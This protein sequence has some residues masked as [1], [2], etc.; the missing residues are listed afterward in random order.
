[1]LLPALPTALAAAAIG[2]LAPRRPHIPA[3]SWLNFLHTPL[4]ATAMAAAGM[5]LIHYGRHAT[6]PTTK[7][8]AIPALYLGAAILG[9]GTALTLP[10]ATGYQ[11]IAAP[12]LALA[13]AI[14]ATGNATGT[15]GTLYAL[16][17][18][19]RWSTRLAQMARPQQR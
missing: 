2:L 13:A 7:D 4:I 5:F 8:L 16:A 18:A 10:L 9:I 12:P 6:S 1:M 19:T 11:I 17:A 3:P 15:L 14:L